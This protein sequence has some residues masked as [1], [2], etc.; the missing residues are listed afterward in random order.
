MPFSLVGKV[1]GVMSEK[2]WGELSDI[3]Y[4]SSL[5]VAVGKRY[6]KCV[7][8]CFAGDGCIRTVC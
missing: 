1:K 2:N 6:M 4:L 5:S 3:P 7:V 8:S